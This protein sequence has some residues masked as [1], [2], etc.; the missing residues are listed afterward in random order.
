[1][2]FN[3]GT[4]HG[5]ELLKLPVRSEVA[6]SKRVRWKI[7]GVDT[8]IAICSACSLLLCINLS[9]GLITIQIAPSTLTLFRL[10]VEVCRTLKSVAPT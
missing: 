9:A 1:M 2:Q 6:E 4:L 3:H 5:S 8:K 10:R 7:K